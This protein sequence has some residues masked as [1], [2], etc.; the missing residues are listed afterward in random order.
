MQ[1]QRRLIINYKKITNVAKVKRWLGVGIKYPINL[2]GKYQK[3]IFQEIKLEKPI[4]LN[5]DQIRNQSKNFINGIYVKMRI[6]KLG[7]LLALLRS[8]VQLI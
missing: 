2:D 5:L 8:L 4:T 1:D 3:P 7:V 6:V